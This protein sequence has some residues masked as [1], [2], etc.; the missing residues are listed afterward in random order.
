MAECPAQ[1]VQRSRGGEL[2]TKNRKQSER[3]RDRCTSAARHWV[4]SSDNSSAITTASSSSCPG[5][6][7]SSEARYPAGRIFSREQFVRP[8]HRYRCVNLPGRV[9]CYS[10]VLGSSSNAFR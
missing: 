10:Q 1:V 2:G 7:E 4:Y 3:N 8:L 5:E 6:T 9:H